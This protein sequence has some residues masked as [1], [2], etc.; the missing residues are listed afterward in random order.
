LVVEV[1]VAL[2]STIS[3]KSTRKTTQDDDACARSNDVSIPAPRISSCMGALP[4]ACAAFDSVSTHA[5]TMP[6][7]SRDR[8][9]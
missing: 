6:C 2:W 1:V 7:M 4:A 5:D 3:G 8:M 9:W